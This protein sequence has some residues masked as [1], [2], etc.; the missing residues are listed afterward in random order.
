MR[1]FRYG[2]VL[3]IALGVAGSLSLVAPVR[4]GAASLPCDI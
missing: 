3:A 2:L 1:A 4:A